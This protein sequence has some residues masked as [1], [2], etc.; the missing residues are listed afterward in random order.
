MAPAKIN[1]GLD[2]VGRNADGYHT[3]ETVFQTVSLYD[4][5][6]V[7][8][9]PGGHGISF[10]VDSPDIPADENNLAWRAAAR[11]L[12]AAHLS[13]GVAIRLEKHIPSE[14]GLG[15]GS[16]DSAAVLRALQELCGDPLP[17][18]KLQKVALSLGADVPFLLHG[19]TAYAT[20][21]G[22]DLTPLPPFLARHI[23]L[24][25]GHAGVSTKEAY[26]KI[27]A[28]Q[29]PMHPP[30]RKLRDKILAGGT[31]LE[32]ASLCGN[33]FEEVALSAESARIKEIL[34]QSG[35]L[36]GVMTGSGAAVF[37]IFGEE[38]R[39]MAA[40]LEL[41]REGVPFAV[42]CGAEGRS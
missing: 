23:V 25:K 17:E 34:L 20:G 4:R 16:S 33:L 6:W 13:G 22:E 32:I 8:Y 35:A 12:D 3:L 40:L 26:A 2:V 15:G 38:S 24:A 14:A 10:S 42:L 7:S 31:L 27:D 39:A 36:C 11:F 18:E 5:L 29:N 41:R 1:L 21:V 9:D 37:G 19:G 30:V 28:L